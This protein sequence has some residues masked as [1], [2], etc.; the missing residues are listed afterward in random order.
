MALNLSLF[1]TADSD[2][3]LSTSAIIIICVFVL[4]VLIVIVLGIVVYYMHTKWTSNQIKSMHGKRHN[5]EGRTQQN[6]NE[7]SGNF[8]SHFSVHF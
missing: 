7:K 1:S 4:I 2:N 5:E 3:N 6:N 8:V